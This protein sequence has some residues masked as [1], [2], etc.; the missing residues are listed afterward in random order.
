MPASV[1]GVPAIPILT[2]AGSL[3]RALAERRDTNPRSRPIVVID[4][5]VAVTAHPLV[6][7][8]DASIS[9]RIVVVDASGAWGG[10]RRRST[11][12]DAVRRADARATSTSA[13]HTTSTVI[14]IGGG[15]VLDLAKLAR[16]AL[17]EPRSADAVLR[18][19]RSMPVVTVPALDASAPGLILAP[20]TFGTGSEASAAA[21]VESSSGE[22]SSVHAPHR[23][24]RARRLVVGDAFRADVIVLDPALTADA[25]DRLLLEGAAEVILRLLGA[26]I[27]SAPR[28][29]SDSDTEVLLTR[30]SAAGALVARGATADQT[31]DGLVRAG[32]ATTS[33]LTHQSWAL[34]GRDPYAALHWYIA[35][36]LSSTIGA[37]KVP[38]TVRLLGP[39]WSAA[40]A[41]DGRFGDAARIRRFWSVVAAA[42]G[43][44][45][46]PLVGLTQWIDRWR[47][48]ADEAV[49]RLSGASASAQTIVAG[50]VAEAC[51]SVWGRAVPTLRRI[52]PDEIAAV[53]TD[54]LADCGASARG[55]RGLPTA[56]RG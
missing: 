12:V 5:A 14:G 48:G 55:P 51:V 34:V 24:H 40:L 53:I 7:A 43:V 47:L 8:A 19:T 42:A 50:R 29:V 44:D 4:S 46:D 39:L 18:R 31:I 56:E 11:V 16:H 35:N 2:G 3:T 49:V 45:A 17:A 13:D 9:D 10:E 26:A 1:A 36:E 54:S 52:R 32:L 6:V 23:S 41:G 15:T 37:R 27:G 28:E 25:P 38:T 20:T 22:G 30:A 33:T 21:C